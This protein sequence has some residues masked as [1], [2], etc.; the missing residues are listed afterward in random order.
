L[1]RTIIG[2]MGD[3][4]SYQLP[5]AKGYTELDAFL[6]GRTYDRRQQ[7]R[8]EVLEATV[9]QVKGFADAIQCL[10]ENKVDPK[11]GTVKSKAQVAAVTTFE[12]AK[13]L[14]EAKGGAFWKI[15]NVL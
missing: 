5:D 13:A 12:K 15:T 9:E 4:D 7:R 6:R 14:N 2:V 10:T 3:I 11:D 1:E 8:T